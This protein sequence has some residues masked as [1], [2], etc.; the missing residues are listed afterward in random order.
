MTEHQLPPTEIQVFRNVVSATGRD[1]AA[2]TVDLHPDG[3]VHVTGPQ[4]SA[5]YAPATWLSRFSRQLE[6]GFFDGG[7][8]SS[9]A[10][11]RTRD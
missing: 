3:Q 9:P 7:A 6:R 8:G 1:P 11:I 2:F 5:F 10:R 4:G